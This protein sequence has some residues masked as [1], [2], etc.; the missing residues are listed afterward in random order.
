MQACTH[1][2]SQALRVRFL[3]TWDPQGGGARLTSCYRPAALRWGPG[4]GKWSPARPGGP[5]TPYEAAGSSRWDRRGKPVR[6]FW[7]CQ[8]GAQT[9]PGHRRTPTGDGGRK[10]RVPAIVTAAG[11]AVGSRRL[12]PEQ[13]G[14]R[15]PARP[16]LWVGRTAQ[17]PRP[18]TRRLQLR[19]SGK[20]FCCSAR[21]RSGTRS[22]GSRPQARAQAARGRGLRW[23]VL[24]PGLVLG[25]VCFAS[26]SSRFPPYPPVPRPAPANGQARY[27]ARRA[28]GPDA[29]PASGS[30]SGELLASRA[31]APARAP[32]ATA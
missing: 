11:A 2:H 26:P 14:T 24:A 8:A 18:A 15:N 20:V 9:S 6:A 12:S 28:P 27:P 17:R 19:T 7:S 4:V 1:T 13:L 22:G 10:G 25:S 32:Q 29:P 5:A 3:P 23:G 21:S 30:L 16:L 31:P